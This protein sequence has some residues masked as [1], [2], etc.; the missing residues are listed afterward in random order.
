MDLHYNDEARLNRAA[1]LAT[2]AAEIGDTAPSGQPLIMGWV[3]A[4]GDTMF[5]GDG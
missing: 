3:Q 5:V 4:S 1:T 2:Q